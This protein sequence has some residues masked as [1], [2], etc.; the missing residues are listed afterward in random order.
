[1][2]ISIELSLRELFI[3]PESSSPFRRSFG[4]RKLV[5]G[6]VAII[7][8]HFLKPQFTTTSKPNTLRNVGWMFNVFEFSYYAV[9]QNDRYTHL[10]KNIS[11]YFVLTL[12]FF[13]PSFQSFFFP[14]RTVPFISYLHFL[15]WLYSI[16]IFLQ[17]LYT[18]EQ[19][20]GS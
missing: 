3:T 7:L 12:S 13:A 14:L 19:A 8:S 18:I 10:L 11:L 9:P 20:T 16:T 17:R 1:V 5:G 2:C 6:N 4:K 15:T